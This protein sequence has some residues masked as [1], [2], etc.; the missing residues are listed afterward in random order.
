MSAAEP[1]GQRRVVAVDRPQT[2]VVGQV[3]T[4]R[5]DTA[6]GRRGIPS[7]RCGITSGRRLGGAEQRGTAASGRRG[8]AA[9]ERR[10]TATKYRLDDAEY[11]QLR[12]RHGGAGTIG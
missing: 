5:R 8:T 7:G 11:C 6:S 10:G 9:S 1:A 2:G 12:E 4:A 3:A